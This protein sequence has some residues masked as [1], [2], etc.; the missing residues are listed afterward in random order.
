MKMDFQFRNTSLDK[1]ACLWG[2][3]NLCQVFCWLVFVM[4]R[5]RSNFLFC[6][7][8]YISI[9]TLYF[10]IYSGSSSGG[11]SDGFIRQ[12]NC[13]LRDFASFKL[14]HAVKSRFSYV[15]WCMFKAI[16]RVIRHTLAIAFARHQ[17]EYLLQVFCL[18][19]FPWLCLSLLKWSNLC[20]DIN[21]LL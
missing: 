16:R 10:G 14:Y 8:C 17:L 9:I 7:L 3:W 11:P 6:C 13:C 15:L 12:Q 21:Y 5:D 20:S 4:V 19:L 1:I 2:C 18:F